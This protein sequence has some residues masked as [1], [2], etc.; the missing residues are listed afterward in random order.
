MRTINSF[1]FQITKKRHIPYR[2][3]SRSLEKVI[4]NKFQS[5]EINRFDPTTTANVP[6]P[7]PVN[8]IKLNPL[9]LLNALPSIE[10]MSNEAEEKLFAER[11]DLF[12][13]RMVIIDGSNVARK[14]VQIYFL[15][16]LLSSIYHNCNFTDFLG[17]ISHFRYEESKFVWSILNRGASIQK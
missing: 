14:C 10:P 17:Q 4:E 6:A 1:K 13:K 12:E 8:D 2:R 16:H 7:F 5:D 15:S 11:P 3:F 9:A